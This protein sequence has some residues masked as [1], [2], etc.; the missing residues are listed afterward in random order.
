MNQFFQ[1]V[2]FVCISFL[3]PYA[4]QAHGDGHGPKVSDVGIFGGAVSAV[5]KESD[6]AKGTKAELVYKAELV[7]SGDGTVRVYIYDSKMKPLNLT[8]FSKTAKASLI[9]FV[10]GKEDV[11]KFS[12]SLSGKN[13]T[14]KAPKEKSK[15]FNLDVVFEEKGT[16]YLAAFDHLD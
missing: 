12:L 15:P 13:F 10:D 1:I 14:G 5:V 8:D 6:H 3:I 2:I 11:A 4:A 16:K 9:S 7:R